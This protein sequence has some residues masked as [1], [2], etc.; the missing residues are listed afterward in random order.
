MSDEKSTAPVRGADAQAPA[1]FDN[2]QTAITIAVDTAYVLSTG[3]E[4]ISS[5]VYMF[6]NRLSIGS[7]GEGTMSLCTCCH[8]G[9][10]IGFKA[11]PIDRNAGDTVSISG[12]QTFQGG[13]FGSSFG[14]IQVSAGGDY[15]VG[16]AAYASPRANYMIQLKI[17]SGGPQ[18]STCFIQLGASIGNLQA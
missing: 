10:F 4:N 13:V 2:P 6:D 1:G 18:P 16:E 5:G 15:W 7:S 14:P 3:G 12:V 8:A 11:V 9:D 17:T